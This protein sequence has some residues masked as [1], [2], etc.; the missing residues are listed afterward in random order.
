MKIN[1]DDDNHPEWWNLDYRP[2][3][4]NPDH[5]YCLITLSNQDNLFMLASNL[6]SNSV[7]MQQWKVI[8]V[9]LVQNKLIWSSFEALQQTW[10]KTGRL[11]KS[12]LNVEF[13]WH[14]TSSET[15]TDICAQGY[16]R[17]FNKVG[18]YGKG[19]YFALHANYSLDDRYSKPDI[20]GTKRLILSKVI[21][22][23]SVLGKSDYVRP[24]RKCK[25]TQYETMV[26][27]ETEP[28]IYVVC[29][30]HQAYPWLIVSVCKR[31]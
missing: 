16:Y 2:S 9:E 14:G 20:S 28:T 19:V 21:C 11:N 24:P 31:S 23:E 18:L 10:L 12:N 3:V 6:F 29:N 15:I 30:D 8:D 26:D 4:N 7:D 25:D 1:D 27:N 5:N 17:D 13:L 22:G